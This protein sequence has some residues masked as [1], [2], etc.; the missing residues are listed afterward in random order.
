ML[1]QR[2]LIEKLSLMTLI[3][4]IFAI[5]LGAFAE[6]FGFHH[7]MF[8]YPSIPDRFSDFFSITNLESLKIY[9]Y[10]GSNYLPLAY[11][12]LIPFKY[13]WPSLA[14]LLNFGLFLIFMMWLSIAFLKEYKAHTSKLHFYTSII[15]CIFLSYPIL[16]AID[17][18][19]E[20]VWVFACLAMFVWFFQE[21]KYKLSI[22]F[23]AI[24]AAMKIYPAI[25]VVLYLKQ[26]RYS[27]FLLSV[28]LMG[29]A[30]F[31]PFYFQE[32]GVLYNIHLYIA[33]LHQNTQ[34]IVFPSNIWANS[35]FVYINQ[36]ISLYAHGDM[37]ILNRLFPL[38]YKYY[39]LGALLAVFLIVLFILRSRLLL[40]KQLM[41]LV[42]TVLWF[43]Q[44]SFD[45]KLIYLYL[46]FLLFANELK[47]EKFSRQYMWVFI[48]LLMP[49]FCVF[50]GVKHVIFSYNNSLNF[51]VCLYCFVLII[52]EEL[53][54][55]K[56][57]E[58]EFS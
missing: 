18:G 38:V 16:F 1:T 26:R 33:G 12:L 55:R 28:F 8:L 52:Y 11:W 14:I 44:I 35:L 36:I 2:E 57:I 10:S 3:S 4:F 42:I 37:N 41:L 22:V 56:R 47:N 20:E 6:H 21:K 30:V 53:F 27:D 9:T 48:L 29:V 15:I 5:Y 40:W 39:V 58:N 7:Y 31:L 32:G 43:P 25:F 17:R 51:L 19:N 23:V 50:L 34:M 45:Y 13:L 46:P 54:Y 49:K 24:A